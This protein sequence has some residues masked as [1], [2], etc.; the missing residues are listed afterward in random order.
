MEEM[1]PILALLV[2]PLPMTPLD[3]PLQR[4]MM[5]TLRSMAA[6]T[7]THAQMESTRNAQ[8]SVGLT[9]RM[10]NAPQKATSGEEILEGKI[11]QEEPLLQLVM[12]TIA[13]LVMLVTV[14]VQQ[15]IVE[16]PIHLGTNKMDVKNVKMM[17]L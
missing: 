4:K 9:G 17:L 2:R 6:P 16:M 14:K 7:A 10:E 8:L 11:A 12:I 5:E 1:K 13:S 3:L 15:M